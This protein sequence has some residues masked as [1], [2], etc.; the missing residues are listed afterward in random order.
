MGQCTI[1]IYIDNNHTAKKAVRIIVSAITTC[2]EGSH[3]TSQVQGSQHAAMLGGK[4]S[5]AGGLGTLTH[6][7]VLGNFVQL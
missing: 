1:Y 6:M 4:L 5:V 2:I 7:F 3:L